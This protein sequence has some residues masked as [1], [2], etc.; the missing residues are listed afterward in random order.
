[1]KESFFDIAKKSSES[2]EYPSPEWLE[3]IGFSLSE[4]NRAKI[5]R[6]VIDD[7]DDNCGK[8]RVELKLSWFNMAEKEWVADVESYSEG[9]TMENA[10]GLVGSWPTTRAEV[11]LLCRALNVQSWRAKP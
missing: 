11:F 8:A 5:A 7:Y 9:G 6:I 3:S 4:T 2:N 1:M 10:V